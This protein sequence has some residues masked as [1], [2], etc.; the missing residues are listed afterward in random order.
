MEKEL[1]S[2]MDSWVPT[3]DL[4][5]VVTLAKGKLACHSMVSTMPAAPVPVKLVRG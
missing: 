2:H 1:P 5:K 4:P 3:Q